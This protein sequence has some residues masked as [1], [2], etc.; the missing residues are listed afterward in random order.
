MAENETDFDGMPWQLI[1]ALP[2]AIYVTDPSGRIT[3]FN[4]AAAALW[5]YRPKL[6]S[7]VADMIATLKL[8]LALHESAVCHECPQKKLVDSRLV[9]K[10]SKRT[11]AK[12][13][14]I[15]L[16]LLGK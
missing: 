9:T 16:T 6:H 4:E 1:D 5:G 15:A 14:R 8:G 10:R 11:R 12:A 7:V 2:A 13:V 3:Y